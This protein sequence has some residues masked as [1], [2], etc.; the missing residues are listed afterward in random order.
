[1]ADPCADAGELA[2]GVVFRESSTRADSMRRS[3][4]AA[5][6]AA[7]QAG[8]PIADSWSRSQFLAW[9]EVHAPDLGAGGLEMAVQY[10]ASVNVV[11]QLVAEAKVGL[12]RQVRV[13]KAGRRALIVLWVVLKSVAGEGR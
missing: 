3:W 4:F 10:I 2:W 7:R 11:E 12:S 9:V 1:M 13:L 5:V 8:V 6:S